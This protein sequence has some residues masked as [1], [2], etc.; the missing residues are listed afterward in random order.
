MAHLGDFGEAPPE[1][2]VDTFNFF[3]AS[4]RI[5]PELSDLSFVDFIEMHGALDG[6]D[7]TAMVAIKDFLRGVVHPEDFDEFWTLSKKNR[8]RLDDLA[9]IAMG[10]I[11]AVTGRP[12]EGSSDS[13]SG[14]SATG[15]S[16]MDASYSRVIQEH[17]AEGRS[18]LAEVYVIAQ[19]A[20]RAS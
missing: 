9:P 5:N 17:E 16:S 3:G 19:A 4:L 13:S 8:Q 12:T 14:P 7:P 11:E 15:A 6:N 18:D 20:L 2:E 1:M 10:L